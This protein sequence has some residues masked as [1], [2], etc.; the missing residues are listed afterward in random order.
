[1]LYACARTQGNL[2]HLA[3][4]LVDRLVGLHLTNVA[5]RA[6][7]EAHVYLS[8]FLDVHMSFDWAAAGLYLARRAGE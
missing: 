6:D 2:R 5:E 4:S 7:P 1:M 8:K 3:A